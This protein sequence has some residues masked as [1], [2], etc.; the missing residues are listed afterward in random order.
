MNSRNTLDLWGKHTAA[1]STFQKTDGWWYSSTAKSPLDMNSIPA[2][3][4][5]CSISSCFFNFSNSF[6]THCTPETGR[7]LEDEKQ[8]KSFKTVCFLPL[9]QPTTGFR[10]IKFFSKWFSPWPSFPPGAPGRQY[11]R[12]MFVPFPSRTKC[13]VPDN[14]QAVHERK[15]NQMGPQAFLYLDTWAVVKMHLT[16]MWRG[17]SHR[18]YDGTRSGSQRCSYIRSNCQHSGQIQC[19]SDHHEGLALISHLTS[20]HSDS[21][22]HTRQRKE[23]STLLGW[24]RRQGP[25]TDPKAA[26]RCCAVQAG[27]PDFI[28]EM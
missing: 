26:R 3:A 10:S 5:S 15:T 16:V 28:I 2:A 12:Q 7:H 27:P 25:N 14:M 23:Q 8:H 17:C 19:D 22:K 11:Q 21:E 9:P 24:G 18:G 6:L 20:H 4:T 13:Q 1:S